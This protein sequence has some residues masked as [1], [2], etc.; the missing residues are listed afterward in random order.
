MN[1]PD[2]LRCKNPNK[3]L[4]NQ[5]HQTL[6]KSYTTIKMV[7]HINRM[8]AKNHMILVNEE[9]ALHK[10]QHHFMM[11]QNRYRGINLNIIKA[12]CEKLTTNILNGEKLK[13]F[14]LRSET[15]KD[16]NSHHFSLT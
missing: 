11:F 2:E 5:I 12:I 8:K 13:A 3:I 1:I 4:A 16:V 9:K 10:I 7:Q 14:P 15:D 6:N